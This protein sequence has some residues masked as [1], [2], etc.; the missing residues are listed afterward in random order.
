M[1]ELSQ[2]AKK[3]VNSFQKLSAIN[4]FEGQGNSTSINLFIPRFEGRSFDIL[5]IQDVLMEVVRD[6]ALSR[7][8]IKKYDRDG[9]LARLTKE[10][11]LKFRAYATNKG[12]LG[13]LLLYT[14]LE[15]ELGAPQIL[16]KMSLKTTPGDYTKKSDGIHYLKLPNSDR[17]HL[18]FGEAKMYKQLSAGFKSALESIADHQSGK[19]FEK[20]LISSQIENEFIEESDKVLINTILYPSESEVEI[21]VSDAFGIFIGFEIDDT[22]GQTKTED[23]C[24]EWLKSEIISTVKSR[25]STIEG[26]I[27]ANDLVGKNFYVYLMPFIDLDKTREEITKGVTE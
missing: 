10:A 15:G 26:Y 4:L 27:E 18:I 14:F 11:R 5:G 9:K 25:I 21:K 20:S 17:Y 6:F 23:E 3:A 1:I 7:I 24:E 13:E 12:E 8:R 2:N 19:E 22:E 16:S